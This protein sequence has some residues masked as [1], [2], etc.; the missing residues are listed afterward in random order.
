M[1]FKCTFYVVERQK[2]AYD[3][4]MGGKVFL[5]THLVSDPRKLSAE[6]N[7][8]GAPMYANTI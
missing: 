6:P 4:N 5:W 2:F 8:T 3:Q 7:F 1:F